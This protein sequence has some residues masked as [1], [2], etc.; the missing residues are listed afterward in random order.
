MSKKLYSLLILLLLSGAAQSKDKITFSCALD[1]SEVLWNTL[2]DIYSKAFAQLNYD[3]EMLLVPRSRA[4]LSA[5]SQ[6]SDG[7]CGRPKVLEKSLSDNKLIFVDAAIFTAN[8]GVWSINTKQTLTAFKQDLK[9]DNT[10]LGITRGST[11]LHQYFQSLQA[12]NIYEVNSTE[13]GIKMLLAKRIKYFSD[14]DGQALFYI[15]ALDTNKEI[16]FVGNV[17]SESYYPLLNK[18]Y[19]HLAAQLAKNINAQLA[20]IG[21]SLTARDMNKPLYFTQR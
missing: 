5:Q 17:Y 13:Q 16:Q 18:K 21:G 1:G 2:A 8:V 20:Q 6:F 3:F 14:F 7:E 15:Q 11:V 12:K 4:V 9:K 10:L 19:Q